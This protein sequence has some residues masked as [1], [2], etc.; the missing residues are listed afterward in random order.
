MGPT[1]SKGILFAEGLLNVPLFLHCGLVQRSCFFA[2]GRQDREFFP[3]RERERVF[4]LWKGLFERIYLLQGQ[5]LGRG[6][7]GICRIKVRVTSTLGDDSFFLEKVMFSRYLY[8]NDFYAF[9]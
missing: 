9:S 5:F 8:W 2:E 1:R 4:L 7:H 6:T 3:P